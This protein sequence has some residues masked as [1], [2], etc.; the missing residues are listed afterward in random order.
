MDRRII[1][2]RAAIQSAYY[3]LLSEK[4]E[5]M[6]VSEIARRANIDRKTFYLHYASVED[7][8]REFLCKC[9]DEL[10][11]SLKKDG[12][13]DCPMRMELVFRAVNRMVESNMECLKLITGLEAGD[14]FWCK[15]HPIL[16]DALVCAY[17]YKSKASESERRLCCN[18]FVAGL[19]HLY[20]DFLRDPQGYTL[21]NLGDIATGI[22]KNGL[23]Q[24]I[25]HN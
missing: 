23:A 19:V 15:V 18:F 8:P 4:N 6:T 5:K 14:Y 1:K 3:S 13:F 17:K 25:E 20:R 11:D 21:E 2:T 24:I 12:Y 10:M 9:V 7:I 22:A 16:V